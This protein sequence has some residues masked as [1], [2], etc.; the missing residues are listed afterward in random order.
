TKIKC[1]I[2]RSK[3]SEKLF[4]KYTCASRLIVIDLSLSSS[5]MVL[6]NLVL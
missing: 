1:S 4:N 6:N 5:K 2:V 3:I